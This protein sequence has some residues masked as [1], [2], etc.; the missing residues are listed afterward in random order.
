MPIMHSC[1]PIQ[2]SQKQ[3]N[4]T[5]TIR[6]DSHHPQ[7]NESNFYPDY[8]QILHTAHVPKSP[9]AYQPDPPSENKTHSSAYHTR[10]PELPAVRRTT[11]VW[12]V[13]RQSRYVRVRRCGSCLN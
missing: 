12:A 11:I 10:T 13:D 8:T 3:T 2:I 7:T 4:T 1:I 9:L 6:F 5:D